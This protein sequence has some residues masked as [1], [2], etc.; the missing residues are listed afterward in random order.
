MRTIIVTLA[1]GLILTATAE[2][3]MYQ[4]SDPATGTV[5]LSGTPPA[6]YRGAAPGPRTFVFD[7]GQ[8]VDDT[9]IPVSELQ[10]RALREQAFG[11]A[12][13]A[14]LAPGE[15]P[16]EWPA[17]SGGDAGALHHTLSRALDAGIDIEAAA[18]EVRAEQ[19]RAAAARA[20]A[21]VDVAERVTQLKALIEAWDQQRL[22]AARALIESLPEA[23]PDAAWERAAAAGAAP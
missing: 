18:A 20:A 16:G 12:N 14:E 2:A 22:E 5:Q 21:D 19:A 7:D 6:W 9:A 11:A 17:E 8:L 3:R 13:S 1:L 23:A 15:S 10:R 4:W